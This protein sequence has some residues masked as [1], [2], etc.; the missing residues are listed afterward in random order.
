MPASNLPSIR[1]KLLGWYE[2]N[3]RDLPWRRTQ[4]PY[5]IWIAETMLQQTQVVTVIPYYER[6]LRAFPTLADLARAPLAKVLTRWAGLGYYRRAE[7][8]SKCA[9]EMTRL[10]GG[11]IPKDHAILRSLPGIGDYTSGALMSIAFGMPFPAIDGNVRRVLRRM[12]RPDNDTELPA[13]ATGLVPKSRAG[14]FNQALM[15]LGATVCTSAKPRCAECPVGSYCLTRMNDPSNYRASSTK[16][17]TR[18]DVSWPLVIIRHNGQILLR[19][20]PRGGILAGLWELPGGEAAQNEN[21]TITLKRHLHDIQRSM[22]R[23]RQIGEIQHGI[24]NRRIRS[25]IF[26]LEL[27]T[28][29]SLPMPL[30]DG[31]WRWLRPSLVHQVAVSAMTH[32]A[33][34]ALESYE[35]NS[36]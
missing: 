25:P 5:A 4:D 29:G 22:A 20:R 18:R 7:N 35:K 15:E 30:R 12:F 11:S 24:T 31:P 27:A 9:K 19:R 26:L 8:L 32:K 13:I 23:S 16:T 21:L 3:Q 14:D 33:L 34:K 2:K 1:R 17:R 10:H 28:R 36:S 6:F